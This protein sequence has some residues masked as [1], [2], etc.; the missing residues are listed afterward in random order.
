M[1]AVDTTLYKPG[2]LGRRQSFCTR[3]KKAYWQT[4]GGEWNSC[5]SR[6]ERL[7][8]RSRHQAIIDTLQSELAN[9][10]EAGVAPGTEDDELLVSELLHATK[11]KVDVAT[12]VGT[13]GAARKSPYAL[14]GRD[15]MRVNYLPL[16]RTD[17]PFAAGSP[18]RGMKSPTTKGLEELKRVGMST[19]W[20][21][22]WSEHV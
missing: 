12:V 20:A 13:S 14:S 22:G 3:R 5:C 16:D 17:L 6:R 18:A 2:S 11:T 8:V 9:F 10:L 15:A 19:C 21:T 1:N 4:G 7:P